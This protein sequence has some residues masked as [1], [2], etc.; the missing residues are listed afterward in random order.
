MPRKPKPASFR[1][2]VGLRFTLLEQVQP[3]LDDLKACATDQ[4]SKLRVAAR[5]NL[6][7]TLKFLGSINEDQLLSTKSLLEELASKYHGFELQCR[8][9][10]IFKNSIWVGIEP[11]DYLATLVDELNDSLAVLGIDGLQKPYVPHVTLARFG[12]EAKIKLSTLQ[13]KFADKEWGKIRVEKVYLY[14][15][16]T[17]P[18]G[19]RYTI[20]KGFALESSATISDG[21][22]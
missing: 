11:D 20:L 19:A 6:H 15:S 5:E 8:G 2:F 9:I 14:K 3:L 7:I 18:E 10:G 4:S 21:Q 16:D 12:R 22:T 17:L 13:E 1:C